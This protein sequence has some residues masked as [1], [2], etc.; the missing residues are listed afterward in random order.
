MDTD[1]W[2]FHCKSTVEMDTTL[3]GFDELRYISMARVETGISVHDANDGTRESIFAVTECFDEDFS[4]EEG[5]GR[6]CLVNVFSLDWQVLSIVYLV[7]VA[8]LLLLD[9]IGLRGH[10]EQ[11]RP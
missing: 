1:R 11:L 6:T 7:L 2:K 5:D 10:P 9:V 4:Q 3:D 8:L